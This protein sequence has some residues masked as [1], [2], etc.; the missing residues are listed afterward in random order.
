[1]SGITG[2]LSPGGGEFLSGA[3]DWR[4]DIGEIYVVARDDV[5]LVAYRGDSTGAGMTSVAGD[6]LVVNQ[7][8]A[9]RAAGAFD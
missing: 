3:P 9:G 7:Q 1:M 6:H 2:N 5:T 8:R 4:R